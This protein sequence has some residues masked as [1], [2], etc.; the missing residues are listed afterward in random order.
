MSWH[1]GRRCCSFL[2]SGMQL[3]GVAKS[4]YKRERERESDLKQKSVIASEAI[5][6]C[7]F[8][9]LNDLSFYFLSFFRYFLHLSF[10]IFDIFLSI[11]SI[12]FLFFF[13][14]TPSLR[15]PSFFFFFLKDGPI[16][17]S[18]SVYFRLFNMSK[19]KLKFIKVWMVSMGFEPGATG[20]KVQT[21]FLNVKCASIRYMLSIPTSGIIR[22]L[23][24]RTH[25]LM[26]WGSHK[27]RSS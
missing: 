1:P 17:A 12:S 25:D 3:A 8:Y 10:D 24:T 9:F 2:S 15:L 16:L 23:K 18:F 22:S 5:F 4:I 7:H 6:I 13:H 21:N 14:L 27:P 11:F 20:W 26:I 19:F